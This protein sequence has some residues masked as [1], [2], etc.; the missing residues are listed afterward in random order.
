MHVLLER[1]TALGDDIAA[2]S[3]LAATVAT[4]RGHAALGAN[5][6]HLF[7]AA[8]LALPGGGTCRLRVLA[9]AAGNPMSAAR[10]LAKFQC[11]V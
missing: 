10:S 3:C 6:L 4:L 1:L 11:H 5:R 9:I 2:I 8:R 7:C